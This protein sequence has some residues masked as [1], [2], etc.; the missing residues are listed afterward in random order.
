MR[1]AVLTVQLY[2]PWA[3]SLKEKRAELKSLL[4]K[5]Q[6]KF[7]IS[8][9]ETARQDNHQLLVFTCAAVA[10]SPTQA[11]SILGNLLHYIEGNTEAEVTVLDREVL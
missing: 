7:N 8:V 3:H 4:G 10:A 5:L 11:D 9:A 1:I 2:A 6:T